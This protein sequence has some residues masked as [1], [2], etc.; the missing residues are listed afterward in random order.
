MIEFVDNISKSGSYLAMLKQQL[1]RVAGAWSIEDYRSFISFYSSILPSL[2]KVER[3]AVFVMEMGSKEICSIFGTGIDYQQIKP[4]LVGSIVGDVINS[5]ESFLTNELEGHVGYHTTIEEQTGFTGRNMIC[6]PIKSITE[7]GATGALQILNKEGTQSFTT[8]DLAQLEEVA[9]FLSFSIESIVLNQEILRIASS[10]GEE[11]GRLEQNSINGITLIAESQAMRDVLDLVRTVSKSP[12]NVLI[13]GENGT[14]KELIAR[15]IHQLGSR[16]EQP[17]VA[18]NCA[19]IPG[20]LM[21]SQFFGHEKGAFTGAQAVRKGL[22]EE[23]SGGTLFLDEIGEMSLMMQ[24]KVLR[25]I[26]EEEGS[27]VGGNVVLHYDLRIVSA[28]NRDLPEEVQQNRFREDLFFRLFSVEI[29]LPPLRDRAE[30]ILPLSL[31]FLKM[32][33]ER[34]DKNVSGFSSEVISL[35]EIFG[36]PGN[37]RQLQKEIERLV[38]LT[39]DGQIIQPEQLSRDLHALYTIQDMGAGKGTEGDLALPEQ[40]KRLEIILINKAMRRTQGNKSKAAKLLDISRQGLDKK[41]KRHNL[42]TTRP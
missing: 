8:T 6:V 39:P 42:T 29:I 9:H 26:Q 37:V 2:M 34:F 31:H 27:R 10:L 21:E 24:P 13:Q 25:A 17:F 20:N 18:V 40:I 38:A 33:N 35:F 16:R 14:G 4:P 30:D 41:I 36:W 19:S 15:M 28:T 22:F 7:T 32:T 5:G 12:V 1:S 3:C 23:A 11:V